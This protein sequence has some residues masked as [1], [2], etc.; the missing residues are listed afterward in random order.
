MRMYSFV[1][2]NKE[3]EYIVMRMKFLKS[4]RPT[5]ATPVILRTI[6]KS[7]KWHTGNGNYILDTLSQW[8]HK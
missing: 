7:I 4:F 2:G 5:L 1:G 3:N 6:A 8:A